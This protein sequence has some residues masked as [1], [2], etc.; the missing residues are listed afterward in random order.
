MS[1]G[2]I[3]W[4]N[5]SHSSV[6]LAQK[7]VIRIIMGYGYKEFCRELFKELKILTLSSQYILSL[8]SFIVNNRHY[9]VSNSVYHNINIRQKNIYTCLSYLW[10]C[11][12]REFNI[13]ASK[14]LSLLKPIKDISSKPKC[15]KLL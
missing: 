7:R 14:F 8:L 10:P 6:F 13:Q 2:I 1:Y 15:L 3:F 4:G 12:R 11:I 5:S 9:F